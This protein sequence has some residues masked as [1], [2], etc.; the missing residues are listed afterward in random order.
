MGLPRRVGYGDALVQLVSA[1]KEKRYA[2]YGIRPTDSLL[3]L[4]LDGHREDTVQ[5]SL[6]YRARPLNGIW[7][8]PPYLHNASVPNLYQLLSPLEERPERFYL[9]SRLF[10]PVYVGFDYQES[11]GAFEF[12]TSLPGNSNEGHLFEGERATWEGKRGVL[13]PELSHRQRLDLIEYLKWLPP[14]PV[15]FDG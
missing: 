10:D 7:A 14:L 1:V 11:P 5:D 13:G 15:R 4:E 12:D 9:G 3:R 8:T 6:V 2:D